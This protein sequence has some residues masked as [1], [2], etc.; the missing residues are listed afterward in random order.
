MTEP[1]LLIRDEGAVR[2]LTLNRP[3]KLNA[4]DHA[5][6]RALLDGLLAAEADD[7]IA[8]VVLT[9]AGRA[10]CAGADIGEFKQLTPDNA[11]LVEERAAM[12]TRTHHLFTQMKK[13][14][15]AAVNGHAVAGG[16]GYALACDLVVAAENAQFGYPEVKRGILPAIV[17][18]NLVRQ[19][20]R[21]AAFELV[22][23]GEH[24]SARR[25]AEL[26]MLNHVVPDGAALTEALAIATTL[27]KLPREALFATKRAFHAVADLPLAEALKVGEKANADMRSLPPDPSQARFQK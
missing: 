15:I 9:G 11:K 6:T 8:V 22:I 14:V 26:G 3:Q 13:P 16:C 19:V 18:A 7:G 2:V 1:V 10:F 5:L 20:G 12:S 21:K 23:R 24:I 27:A 17:L 4:L 25:A